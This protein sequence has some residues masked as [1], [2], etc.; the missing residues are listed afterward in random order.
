MWRSTC[1]GHSL[2]GTSFLS[3][4]AYEC[5]CDATQTAE[6]R[7]AHLRA[8]YAEDAAAALTAGALQGGYRSTALKRDAKP[9]ALRQV[10]VFTL[11]SGDDTQEAVAEAAKIS[12]GT[13][14]ARCVRRHVTLVA[15]VW[16][17]S[18]AKPRL[19]LVCAPR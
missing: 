17:L 14:L 8:R 6:T 18:A 2:C 7:P 16:L 4:R 12:L 5:V 15:A 9:S 10:T 19:I 1:T 11:G 13:A 3:P